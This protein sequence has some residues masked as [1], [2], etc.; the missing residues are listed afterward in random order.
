[1]SRFFAVFALALAISTGNGFAETC[2]GTYTVQRGDSLSHIADRL[3]KN[4][5]QWTLI[6][7][8]NLNEIGENPNSILVGQKL[9]LSCIG[10]VP[11]GLTG[12]TTASVVNVV[13]TEAVTRAPRRV[14]EASL[15]IV[16]AGDFAPFTGQD[17]PGSGLIAEVVDHAMQSSPAADRY[18][19][20]W[21][22]DWS[23]HLEPLMTSTMMDMAFPWFKPDCASDPENFRC[24]NFYFSDPM[25]ETLILLF[26]D[27]TRPIPFTSDA[28]MHGRTLCRPNGYF[29]HDLD[30]EGRRWVSDKL[31]DLVQPKTVSD[32]FDL[33]TAGDVDAVAINEFTGRA[34]IKSLKLEGRVDVLQGRPLSIE[35]LH[36]LV[37]KDHPDAET[38]LDM[39]NTGLSSIKA[40]GS[41]QRVV[42]QHMTRIWAEF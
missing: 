24:A 17:L 25:F 12:A 4:A 41:Y 28:D 13:P 35:G 26:V 16:T 40:N 38:L 1:M 22:E 19:V 18:R 32:C 3:Y 9:E 27:T 31:I 37:H 23:S 36:V 42:D 6:Y 30:R 10:G 5:S 8:R 34:A 33:L 21:I 15:N 7:T 20:H 2:G 29:T 14:F 11:T 39:V